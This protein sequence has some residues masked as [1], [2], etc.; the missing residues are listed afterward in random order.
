MSLYNI[1]DPSR[2]LYWKQGQHGYTGD[3]KKAHQYTKILADHICSAPA[4]KDFAVPVDTEWTFVGCYKDI[5]VGIWLVK[6]DVGEYHVMDCNPNGSTIGHHFA[7][8]EERV[9]AYK[10]LGELL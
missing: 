1:F 3:R 8:D 6:L 7:F 9:V 10:S 2:G 5:P 4:V